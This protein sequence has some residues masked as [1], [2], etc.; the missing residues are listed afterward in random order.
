VTTDNPADAADEI[1]PVDPILGQQRMVA[2]PRISADQAAAVLGV[3]VAQV[4]RMVAKG[5]LPAH[6]DKH[7]YRR[8]LLSDVE[9]FRDRGEPIP[10]KEAAQILRCTSDDIRQLI[11]ENQL[12]ARP[13]SRRPVYRKEIEQLARERN[14]PIRRTPSTQPTRP[15]GHVNTTEAAKILSRSISRT[16]QLAAAGRIPAHRD[17][18]GNYWYRPDHLEMTRRAWQ[19]ADDHERRQS[20]NVA[21]KRVARHR[22]DDQL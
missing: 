5:W 17:D 13:G 7:S 9:A 15:E 18:N 19:A 10:L 1:D 20:D 22:Q 2:D 12:T 16:R 21:L 3:L 6:G 4:Y 8:L 11:T 14:L